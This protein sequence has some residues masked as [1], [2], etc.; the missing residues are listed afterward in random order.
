MEEIKDSI[1]KKDAIVEIKDLRFNGI[2]KITKIT[3]CT[4]FEETWV[5]AVLS[6]DTKEKNNELIMEFYHN[7]ALNVYL[8]KPYNSFAKNAQSFPPPV[9][10]TIE[11]ENETYHS[12]NRDN[13]SEGLTAGFGEKEIQHWE[14]E[15]TNGDRVLQIILDN[16]YVDMYTGY[17]VPIIF[18]E[19]Y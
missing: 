6:K 10:I 16:G 7:D 3:E 18:L 9:D 11:E 14:Y 15:N 19:I 1:L 13:Q 5:R 17:K 4:G 8:F 2:Y 12:L